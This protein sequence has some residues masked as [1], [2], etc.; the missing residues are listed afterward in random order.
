MHEDVRLVYDLPGPRTPDKGGKIMPPSG[1]MERALEKITVE[2]RL[3]TLVA[4]AADLLGG[5]DDTRRAPAPEKSYLVCDGDNLSKIA[6]LVYGPEQGNRWANIRRIYEANRQ[7]LPSM[8]SVR[9][10]QK[11]NIPVLAD[12]KGHQ[13]DSLAARHPRGPSGVSA[14][15]AEYYVVKK[16]DSL[17]R[18]AQDQLGDGAR[19]AEIAKLNAGALDDESTIYPGKRLRLPGRN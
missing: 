9:A 13:A 17:W 12:A 11:L 7:L 2:R 15:P 6:V 3:R 14:S 5:K 4:G 16:G 18:I 10:G 8:D 1:A 19:F